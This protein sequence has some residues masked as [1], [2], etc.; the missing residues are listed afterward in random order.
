[1]R[2]ALASQRTNT[3]TGAA[4]NRGHPARAAPR[5]VEGRPPQITPPQHLKTMNAHRGPKAAHTTRSGPRHESDTV[6]SLEYLRGKAP[7]W[8]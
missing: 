2:Q 7:E 6:E 3:P 1:M 4:R 5:P 8:R